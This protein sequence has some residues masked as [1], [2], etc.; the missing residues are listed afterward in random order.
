MWNR[1]GTRFKQQR[2]VRPAKGSS[3]T[4]AIGVGVCLNA[5]LQLPNLAGR[6]KGPPVSRPS[7]F[8]ASLCLSRLFRLAEEAVGLLEGQLAEA[9]V[10]PRVAGECGQVRAQF[11]P[12]PARVLFGLRPTDP[13]CREP[14]RG[15]SARRIGLPD[16]WLGLSE[17]QTLVPTHQLSPPA[18]T[19]LPP[20]RGVK[21]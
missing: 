18:K 16:L 21:P 17:G 8:F 3:P 5:P 9:E 12:R 6:N 2:L 13:A 20:V 1:R 4:G 19:V 10:R 15:R 11:G 7:A 14:W